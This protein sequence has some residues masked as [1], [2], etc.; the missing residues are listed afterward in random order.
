[1]A[2]PHRQVT[3]T[4]LHSERIRLPLGGNGEGLSRRGKPILRGPSSPERAVCQPQASGQGLH[5]QDPCF[6]SSKD[7]LDTTPLEESIT[8][9]PQTV[10]H[11]TIDGTPTTSPSCYEKFV[12]GTTES[13]PAVQDVDGSS[14]DKFIDEF[15]TAD[16]F[17]QSASSIVSR[18]ELMTASSGTVSHNTRLS[19]FS[20]FSCEKFVAGAAE[21]ASGKALQDPHFASSKALPDT[22]SLEESITAV[23][24]IVPHKTIDGSPSTLQSSY[25]KFVSGAAETIPTRQDRDVSYLD[26]ILDE[27]FYSSSETITAVPKTVSHTTIDGSPSTLQSSCG[28]L[29]S[30]SAETTIPAL[31]D[32]YDS[33]LNS[34]INEL[35]AELVDS[36]SEEST[37][38][39]PR[40]VPHNATNGCQQSA[41]SI[42][43]K[44]LIR[45][46]MDCYQAF[47]IRMDRMGSFWTYPDVGGPFPSIHEAEVAII[48]FIN[49]LRYGARCKEQY[50]LSR[51]DSNYPYFLKGPPKR[52]PNWQSSKNTYDE[53][54]YLVQA[55]LDQYNSDNDL[56]GDLAHELKDLLKWHWIE[57]DPWWYYHFNFTTKRKADDSTD[58]KLFFAEVSHFLGEK[59][60]EIN[61]CCIIETE[62][63]GDHCHGCRNN[64]DPMKHPKNT[65]AYTGGHFVEGPGVILSDYDDDDDYDNYDDD[66]DD[67]FDFDVDDGDGVNSD[68]EDG[69]EEVDDIVEDCN[70]GHTR[71]TVLDVVCV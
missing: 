71:P 61:C 63:D 46:H 48:Y 21:F 16:G 3:G 67:D 49:V 17:Q 60:F 19:S 59:A 33:F 28:K 58:N 37:T 24:Q 64:R 51:G 35:I 40:I 32:Q 23:P 2:G 70:V 25:E 50:D 36:S 65:N 31:E 18:E 14:L 26:K 5:L 4:H 22:T 10:P 44:I 56:F 43:S 29:V 66:D 62:D 55:L 27:I 57:E 30:G 7:L 54:Q 11:N 13:L 6:A 39:S 1:M 52:D 42:G 53:K 12:A 20:I 69:D 8:A 41:S 34:A 9:V 38:A 68:R 45:R 15:T 47:Y